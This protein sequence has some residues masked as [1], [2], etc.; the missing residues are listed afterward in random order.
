MTQPV[1]SLHLDSMPTELRV[2]LWNLFVD[3]YN[4]KDGGYWKKIT[5]HVAKYFRKFPVDDLPYQSWDLRDWLK[6][7]FFGLSWYEAYNFV[8]FIVN[9]HVAAT[10]ERSGRS[11]EISRHPVTTEKLEAAVNHILEREHSGYRFTAHVLSPISDEAELEEV[12]R[13]TELQGKGLE[14]ARKHIRT[15]LDLFSKRPTP[16]LSQRY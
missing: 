14:G 16:G 15:A 12:Q 2:S 6:E 11:Y 4:L 13:A 5:A 7:Y 8:E 9:N 3:S 10:E 1:L